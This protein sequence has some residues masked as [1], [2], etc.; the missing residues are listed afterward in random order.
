MPI[1]PRDRTGKLRFFQAHRDVWLSGG[2]SIGLDAETLADFDAD[3]AAAKQ[4]FDEQQALRQSA[5]AATQKWNSALKRLHR[6]GSSMLARIKVAAKVEGIG[7]YSRAWVD[8]PA[9]PSRL[10]PPGTPGGFQYKL[11]PNGAL[12]LRWACRV[13]KGSKGTQYIVRRSVD[14]GKFVYLDRAGKRKFRDTTLPLGASRIVYEIT[15][16]RSTGQGEAARFNVNFGVD[17][18]GSMHV[19]A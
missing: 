6:L 4:A 2:E 19:A 16:S 7:V 8:A 3:L 17:S 15:A 5:R 9:R 18:E 14:G 11:L 13:P 12:V 10:P 1:V